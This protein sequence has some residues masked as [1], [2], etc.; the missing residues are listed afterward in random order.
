[1][2]LFDIFSKLIGGFFIGGLCGLIPLI[3]GIV[4]KKVIFGII[5]ACVCVLFGILMTM[6][7]LQP[8]FLSIIPSAIFTVFIFVYSAALKKHEK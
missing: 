1:M 6:V 5:G 4:R 2:E 8:A 3:I 7:F